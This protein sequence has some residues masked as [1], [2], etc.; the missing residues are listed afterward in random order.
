MRILVLD[1]YDS[2]TYNLVQSLGELGASPVVR[3]NDRITVAQAL[4][5][6]YQ[7]MVISPGPGRPEEAGI[8]VELVRACGGARPLLGV[9]LGHQAIAT[10]FGGRVIPAPELKHGKTGQVDHDG[11]GLFHGLSSPLTVM[12]YHSLIVD[13]ESLPGELEVTA[14]GV[15]ER[16]IQAMRHR[17]APVF[18]VQFHPESVGTAEGNAL[19]GNFLRLAAGATGLRKSSSATD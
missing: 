11:S 3:R 7:A 15:G 18:G 17:D 2:F 1:N 5:D 13:P 16:E 8:S 12:R 14:T 4:E 10:A 6:D 19:L 9:C